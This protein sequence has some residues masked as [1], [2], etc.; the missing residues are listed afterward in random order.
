MTYTKK[1][2]KETQTVNK[3]TQI[4]TNSKQNRRK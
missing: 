4:V 2:N 3:E 1:K